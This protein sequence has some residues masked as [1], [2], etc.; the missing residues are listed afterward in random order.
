VSQLDNADRQALRELAGALADRC[1]TSAVVRAAVAQHGTPDRALDAELARAG[2][3]GLEIP[4]QYGGGGAGFGELAIALEQLGARAAPSR[5]TASA[6]LCAGAVLLAGTDEQ[7]ARWLPGLANGDTSGTAVLGGFARQDGRHLAHDLRAERVGGGWTLQGSAPHVLDG[8]VSDLFVVSASGPHGS[9]VAVVPTGAPT[10]TS[11]P[12]AFTDGT[13]CLDAVRFSAVR[14]AEAD[15]LAEGDAAVSL[16]AAL[17]NRAA[18]AL[19]ADSV[20]AARQL[21]DLTVAYALQREQFG[22]PIGGFQ[23]VKHH[24]ANMLVNVETSS[25]LLDGAIGD[26]STDPR[27]S[28]G[29]ASMAKEFCTERAVVTAGTALQV[30]GGIGYTWEHDL[31]LYFKRV[32]LNQYLFGD[33]RWHRARIADYLDRL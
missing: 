9:V 25:A 10:L 15:V 29:P 8:R 31:H 32:L 28:S 13:R 14:V 33:V 19:A 1:A 6:V 22:R 7:R 27:S 12:V 26:V 23:A 17:V 21:L 30:H 20:G 3:F 4:D 18:V 16:H 5:L 24:A 2:L 11:Q